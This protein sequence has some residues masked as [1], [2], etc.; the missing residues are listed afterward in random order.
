[1]NV[2]AY[3]KEKNKKARKRETVGE[4]TKTIDCLGQRFSVDGLQPTDGQQRSFRWA[5]KCSANN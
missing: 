3:Q 4:K 1:M 5:A 2:V